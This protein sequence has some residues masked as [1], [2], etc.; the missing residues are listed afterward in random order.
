MVNINDL[1]L[2]AYLRQNSRAH[3]MDISRESRIPVSTL[4]DRL[5]E[6][7]GSSILRHTCI[8]DFSAVGF[9]VKA[10]VLFKINKNDKD[11]VHKFLM[12]SFN[13]NNLYKI[14]NGYDFIAEFVFRSIS[15]MEGFFDSLDQKFSIKSKE[16]HYIISDLKREAF[17]SSPDFI[18]SLFPAQQ[19][20]Q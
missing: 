16:V 9:A 15:E 11:N 3:L 17:L 14:N 6:K 12:K 18:P 20:L 8:V 1:T 7:A 10:H 4:H 13:V 2:L 5:M 19:E